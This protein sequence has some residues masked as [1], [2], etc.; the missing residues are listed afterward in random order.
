MR[1]HSESRR[2]GA[3]PDTRNL[4][5]RHFPTLMPWCLLVAVEP[6]LMDSR[7]LICGTGIVTVVHDDWTGRRLREI[8][9]GAIGNLIFEP[10]ARTIEAREPVLVRERRRGTGDRWRWNDR[11]MLPYA[12]G[13]SPRVERLLSITLFDRESDMLA[14][15]DSIDAWEVVETFTGPALLGSSG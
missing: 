7:I 8:S 6:V 5:P 12:H 4:D 13:A 11:L 15:P 3:L 14:W 9:L 10:F 2:A 1:W